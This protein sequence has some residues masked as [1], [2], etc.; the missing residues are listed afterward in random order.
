MKR[1]VIVGVGALGFLMLEYWQ[2]VSMGKTWR[3][4][5]RKSFGKKK[6][7]DHRSRS[8]WARRNNNAAR[9]RTLNVDLADF[10]DEK[11]IQ[12]PTVDETS[13]NKARKAG[14]K[15]PL[16]K[17]PKPVPKIQS[18]QYSQSV[19]RKKKRLYSLLKTKELRNRL[20]FYQR[21]A[22][23]AALMLR[24]GNSGGRRAY[25]ELSTEMKWINLYLKECRS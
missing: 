25:R 19:P 21:Q 14:R 18:R 10:N 2:E 22:K 1:E 15:R 9:L 4:P 11:G 20:V 12:A 8:A 13:K 3:S 7:K 5:T 6:T 24:F 17:K 23:F 16:S